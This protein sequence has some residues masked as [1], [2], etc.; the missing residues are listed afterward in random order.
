MESTSCIMPTMEFVYSEMLGKSMFVPRLTA[1]AIPILAMKTTGSN[2]ELHI[3]SRITRTSATEITIISGESSGTFASWMLPAVAAPDASYFSCT[4]L[5]SAA[6]SFEWLSYPAVTS[7]RVYSFR[8]FS[9]FSR[10]TAVTCSLSESQ[11][12]ISSSSSSVIPVNITRRTEEASFP[13][14]PS[15]RCMPCFIPDSAGRYCARS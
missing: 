6:A 1:T 10:V 5:Y 13:N 4:P 2:Q 15:I 3:S 9:F 12:K 11:R 8:S 7:N 14:S